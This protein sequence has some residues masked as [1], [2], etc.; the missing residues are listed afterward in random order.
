MLRVS[1]RL[2]VILL[3]TATFGAAQQPADS[4]EEV[5]QLRDLVLKLQARVDELEKKL[6]TS[7]P[8]T[9]APPPGPVPQ[10]PSVPTSAT[11]TPPQPES[12]ATEGFAKGQPS[13]CYST[14]TTV[15]TS[16]P[17]SDESTAFGRMM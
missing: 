15:I 16:T 1:W 5:S 10:A 6:E 17:Q 2:S 13:T 7:T 12:P 11:A 4:R 9:K 8:V 14:V 3:Y